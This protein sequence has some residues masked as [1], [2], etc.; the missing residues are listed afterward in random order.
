MTK[1]IDDL[2][3]VRNVVQALEPFDSKDRERI[4]RWASEKLGMTSSHPKQPESRLQKDI[5]T[6]IPKPLPQSESA[7]PSQGESSDIRSFILSKDPK[8]DNHLAAV[9]AYYYHFEAPADEQK[10]YITKEDLIDACRKADRKRP[11]RPAQVLVNTYA[12]GLLDKGER[13]QYRLNSVGE[14]L[15]AMVLPETQGSEPRSPGPSRKRVTSRKKSVKAKRKGAKKA[16]QKK[17]NKTSR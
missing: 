15:V 13:G 12:A 4:I 14:N 6:A 8:N 11:A 5:S 2:E 7:I 10:D 16:A 17:K 3:A 9:V 1:P